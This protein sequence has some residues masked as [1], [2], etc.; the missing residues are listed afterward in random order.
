MNLLDQASQQLVDQLI[1]SHGINTALRTLAR[2]G[3]YE[4]VPPLVNDFIDSP[5]FCGDVLGSGLFP[6]W[7]AALHQIYPNPFYSPYL[8][9]VLTGCLTGDTK[10]VLEDGSIKTFSELVELYN[11][12]NEIKVLSYNIESKSIEVKLATN[13]R[14]TDTNRKVY[15][16]KLSDGSEIKATENHRFLL[17]DGI[18]WKRLDELKPGDE[19]LETNI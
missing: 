17:S 5:T 16:I 12:G 11:S 3:G 2:L 1:E 9:I 4:D 8:E 6:T 19:L 7:R 14:I 18:T 10:I 15:K 13:I